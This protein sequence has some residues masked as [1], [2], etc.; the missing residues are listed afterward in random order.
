MVDEKIFTVNLRKGYENVPNYQRTKVAVRATKDFLR[1]H[2][3]K[4]VLLGKYL[5]NKLHEHGKKN[6]PHK[7]QIKVWEEK[8]KW[9]ADLVGAPVEK[10]KEEKKKGKKSIEARVETKEDVKEGLTKEDKKEILEHPDKKK[11]KQQVEPKKKETMQKAGEQTR[12]AEVYS[13]TQKPK[14]EKKK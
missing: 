3:K 10:P 5:N 1:K 6:P 12:K 8:E 11:E 4:E 2:I 14:H 9:K 13:K 7:V